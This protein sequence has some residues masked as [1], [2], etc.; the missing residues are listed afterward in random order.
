M[1]AVSV[2]MRLRRIFGPNKDENKVYRRLTAILICLGYRWRQKIHLLD[3]N[4][5]R[6]TEK[7]KWS[8]KIINEEVLHRL[9]LCCI[10]SGALIDCIWGQYK[11]FKLASL[12]EKIYF[13]LSS[14]SE[15]IAFWNRPIIYGHN[16]LRGDCK[17]YPHNVNFRNIFLRN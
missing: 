14:I 17:P 12:T 5:C 6:R 2:L 9:D 8:E 1:F 16:V 4:C 7:M 10:T 3:M 11:N 13:I 15:I